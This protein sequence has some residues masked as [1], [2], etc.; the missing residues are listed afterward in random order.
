[1]ARRACRLVVAVACLLGQA[2]STSARNYAIDDLLATEDIGRAVFDPHDHWL[3]FERLTPFRAMSRFDLLPQSDL[4]RSRLYRVNLDR[5]W[6]P[7]PLL[8]DPRPGTVIYGFSPDGE[9]LA[10]GRLSGASWRLGIITMTSGAV[11]WLTVAPDYDPFRQSL[12]WISNHHI[13]AIANRDGERPWW[14]RAGAFPAEVL[15]ERWRATRSG[16]RAAVTVAG[17][18]RFRDS[19]SPP[20]SNRL[21]LVDAVSLQVSTLATGRFLSLETSPDG[22]QVGL[23]ERGENS[24]LPQN[25]PVGQIDASFRQVPVFYD[26]RR[27]VVWRPC[28]D[29]DQ[30][31]QPRWSADSGRVVLFARHAGED[32]PD[33][34]ILVVDTGRRSMAWRDGGVRPFAGDFPDGTVR[35]AFRWRGSDLMVFGRLRSA[36]SARNDWYVVDGSDASALTRKLAAVGMEVSAIGTCANAMTAA[37]GL[38]CLD[39][40]S[41]TRLFAAGTRISNGAAVG[42]TRTTGGI[43]ITGDAL[44]GR[45]LA[46]GADERIDG[47][48]VSFTGKLLLVRRTTAQG[49]KSLTLLSRAG[50]AT[51]A[52]VN[53]WLN[54]V[55][56]AT[57]MPLSLALPDGVSVTSWLYLPPDSSP[58]NK[59]PLIVIPYPGRVYGST[60]P[61][62]QE[63]GAARFHTSAQLL[64][65]R[66]YA[67]LLPSLPEH[68]GAGDRMGRLVA[69]LDRSVDAAIATGRTAPRRIALWGHSF[70]GYAVAMA[71]TRSCR[72]A[73]AIVSAGVYDLA[74]IAGTFGLT[75]RLAPER[76]LSI[77]QNF[78]WAE[79]GQGDLAVPPWVDPR[80]YVEASPVYRLGRITTPMLI[81]AADRDISP[82]DQAQQLFAGLARQNKDAQLVTYWGEGHVVSSPANVR[83]LYQRVFN[84]LDDTL[85]APPSEPRCATGS[86]VA[87]LP[88][89]APIA[90]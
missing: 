50:Q 15:P 72:Y 28:P 34:R 7:V 62:E 76:G 49:M 82:L 69:N 64:A 33:A 10:I 25:R 42:W 48:E 54:G 88:T 24:S 61:A 38:W 74:G 56:P 89:R 11:R 71:A 47:I 80:R 20:P 6:R 65:G 37:D 77:G 17:S 70:G 66:G 75:T 31:G 90:P 1:M 46:T 79:T 4:L 68:S 29:C 27:H 14:L 85:V 53:R 83:D 87:D 3:V 5:P 21:V 81:I 43:V 18:G 19:G 63:A 52:Q 8:A 40:S 13:V 2:Q 73:S 22:Y 60:A 23:I 67:V 84:W 32:W 36:P 39:G 51:V 16:T 78:A 55:Q 41:P 45:T 12:R 57:A 35:A 26:V 59:L 44:P 30:L 86:R 9:R 58:T